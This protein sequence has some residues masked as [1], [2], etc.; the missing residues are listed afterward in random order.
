MTH[1]IKKSYLKQNIITSVVFILV[2]LSLTSQASS[3]PLTETSNASE[4]T[5]IPRCSVATTNQGTMAS[6]QTLSLLGTIDLTKLT[7]RL[8]PLLVLPGSD[9]T[10]RPANSSFS[11][12]LLDGKGDVLAHYPFE[13][14]TYIN[15]SQNKDKMALLAEAV[16]YMPCTKAIII[17]KGNTEL[18]SRTV[19]LYSPKV[20]I[21]FPVGGETLNG[22][23]TVKW[24]GSDADSSNLTYFVFYSADSGR[25]WIQL[26]SNIKAQE[27]S[28]N[29]AELPSTNSGLF[30][31]IATDGV[32]TGIADSNGR[33]NVPSTSITA[34]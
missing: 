25:S 13:P 5:S 6:N 30:R 17:S 34:G 24:K 33:F 10:A 21:I 16:P 12:D 14:K 26:A 4:T 19:D 31:V 3:L 32:N 18:V 2:G 29:T 7:T 22:T 28:V 9:L 27:L 23:V 11:I 8:D 20:K 1:K 15:L